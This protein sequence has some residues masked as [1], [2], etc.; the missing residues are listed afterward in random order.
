MVRGVVRGCLTSGFSEVLE[1]WGKRNELG[2]TSEEAISRLT[3]VLSG[4]DVFILRLSILNLIE[5]AGS[6]APGKRYGSQ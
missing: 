2:A 4:V 3:A 1:R 5:S 6:P